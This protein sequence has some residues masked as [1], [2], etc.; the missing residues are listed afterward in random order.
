M[1][2]ISFD[3]CRV[4]ISSA[5][6]NPAGSSNFACETRERVTGQWRSRAMEL[7]ED[8][9]EELI[10]RDLDELEQFTAVEKASRQYAFLPR[11]QSRNKLRKAAS[12][13][14]DESLQRFW[15]PRR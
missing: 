14:A 11:R 4:L 10:D 12:D 7:T 13:E 9:L 5:S 3:Q 2:P 1:L 8:E 15:Q 6:R